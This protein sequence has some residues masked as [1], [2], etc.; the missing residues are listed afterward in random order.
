[1]YVKAS[2]SVKVTD[3]SLGF[4]FLLSWIKTGFFSILWD[5]LCVYR[6]VNVRQLSMDGNLEAK[7]DTKYFP[8]TLPCLY[9][10]A[11]F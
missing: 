10:L 4:F 11:I 5:C 7:R 6:G 2:Y 1:M 3:L 8:S 9:F